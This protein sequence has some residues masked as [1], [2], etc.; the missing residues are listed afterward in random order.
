MVNR[1]R[2]ISQHDNAR[3]QTS[4]KT[5][6]KIKDLEISVLPHPA[7]SADLA[8]SDY[9]LRGRCFQSTEEFKNGCEELFAS[10]EPEWYR[11]GLEMLAKRWKDTIENDGL[12]FQI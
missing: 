6:K 2:V 8:P 4:K 3:P 9:F 5:Q 1:K 12:Y 10:K 11:N 7:Y